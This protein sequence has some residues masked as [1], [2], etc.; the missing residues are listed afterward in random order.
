MLLNTVLKFASTDGG[1]GAAAAAAA[2]AVA[3]VAVAANANSIGG[4]NNASK[5]T[6][7]TTSA[8]THTNITV[9]T[10]A[11][12]NAGACGSKRMSLDELRH[13]LCSFFITHVFHSQRAREVV[14]ALSEDDTDLVAFLV[15]MLETQL[16]LELRCGA[17]AATVAASVGAGVG[18][19]AGVGVCVDVGTGVGDGG[20]EGISIGSIA[21]ASCEARFLCALWSS[22]SDGPSLFL[23]FVKGT[24]FPFK[25]VCF[26]KA[27]HLSCLFPSFPTSLHI[28]MSSSFHFF[29]F[30]LFHHLTSP[31]LTSLHLTLLSSL[32]LSVS[33]QTRRVVPGR[34]S[35]AGPFVQPRNGCAG[36]PAARHQG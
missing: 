6:I 27:L 25:R 33:I 24:R 5:S 7:P 20:G 21:G 4:A 3:A 10:T 22:H 36:V 30:S 28:F 1:A 13:A 14:R 12:A 16:R 8:S 31:H 29:T 17:D 26:A 35:A 19:G 32:S 2:A 15:A 9:S 18:A 34:D 23:C 11:D